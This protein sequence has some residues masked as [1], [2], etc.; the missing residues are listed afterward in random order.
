MPNR[1]TLAANNPGPAQRPFDVNSR[2]YL[3]KVA[4]AL[5][6]DWYSLVATRDIAA[7]EEL[8]NDY[9]EDDESPPYYDALCDQYGVTWDF[10]E[11]DT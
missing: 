1:P 5:T 2:H 9:A 6:D 3:R 4:E 11:E 7:G 10:I 8:T